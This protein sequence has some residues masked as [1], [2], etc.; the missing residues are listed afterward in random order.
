MTKDGWPPE[1]EKNLFGRL[2]QEVGLQESSLV[3]I[4]MMGLSKEHPVTCN[5]A[6]DIV[7][8]IVLRAATHKTGLSLQ[9]IEII[10]LLFRLSE[11]RHPD[12]ISLPLGYAQINLKQFKNI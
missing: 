6:V 7:D 12:N 9:K 10:E 11:Y 2:C 5:E 3:F 4:L 1:S 8:Q